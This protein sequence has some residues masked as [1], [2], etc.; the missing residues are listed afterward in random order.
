[1]DRNEVLKI[2]ED[3][4]IVAVI[5]LNDVAKLE[6]II[7]SISRGG[8][9]A[10]EITMTTPNALDIIGE[11]SGRINNNFVLGV[12][13]VLNGEIAR[14]AIDAGAQ[15]VVSPIFKQELVDVAHL[16]NCPVIPGC[17]TPTEIQTAWEGGADVIKVFPATKL[18]PGFFKDILGPLPHL[19]LTP[20]GGV[21]LE[22]AAKFIKAG[23]VFLGVGTALLDK[24]MIAE[25]RWSDLTDLAKKFINEIKN[26][27]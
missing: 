11:L 1:M 7:D 24:K 5:R 25:S 2:I 6:K 12:G 22:N 10:M 3:S 15:F 23:A 19:K 20:T 21:K 18:G 17:F 14:K 16:N 27:R 9:K 8:V 13:S 4:G 26:C